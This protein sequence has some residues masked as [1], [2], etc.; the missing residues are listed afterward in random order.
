MNCFQVIVL[1]ASLMGFAGGKTA[2]GITEQP[3]TLTL[4]FN[5]ANSSAARSLL[6]T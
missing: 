3:E 1:G 5:G 2:E 4:D 6:P